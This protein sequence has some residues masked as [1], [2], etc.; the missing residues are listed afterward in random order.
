MNEFMET[1]LK[2]IGG[3]PRSVARCSGSETP[4][5]RG[6]LPRPTLRPLAGMAGCGIAC[7]LLVTGALASETNTVHHVNPAEAQKLI[8]DKKVVVLDVRTP[9]EF[10]AG[11]I[12]G[13]T[14]INFHSAEFAKAL[15]GLDAN[16]SYLVH[17]AAGGRS[18]QALPTLKKLQFQSLYHLDGGIKAW[19]KAGFPVEKN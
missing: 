16:K 15:S 10:A 12:A 13:A 1:V 19:E 11:H 8:A 17:C 5:L 6:W 7:L 4:G 2:L 3:W 14:N 18:T 9:K